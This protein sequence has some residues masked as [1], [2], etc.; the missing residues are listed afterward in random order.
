MTV[1]LSHY[2]V[3]I[4]LRVDFNMSN[5][6]DA[7]EK[8][9]NVRK[10]LCKKLPSTY[11]SHFF[12]KSITELSYQK[13]AAD[14]V[15]NVQ[16]KERVSQIVEKIDIPDGFPISK[17]HHNI[18][19]LLQFLNQSGISY[20]V[21]SDNEIIIFFKNNSNYILVW[22]KKTHEIHDEKY[23]IRDGV[24][25]RH[26]LTRSTA[27]FEIKELITLLKAAINYGIFNECVKMQPFITTYI[28]EVARRIIPDGTPY[29]L[30]QIWKSN[31]QELTFSVRLPNNGVINFSK[32]LKSLYTLG[33][34]S[35]QKHLLK[36]LVEADTMYPCVSVVTNWR[37]HIDF[38]IERSSVFF[39]SD[40]L[41]SLAYEYTCMIDN[42]SR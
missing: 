13:N 25:T 15:V 36:A 14:W 32:N 31:E 22:N 6:K 11:T 16:P 1:D 19:K 37:R 38:P 5:Y 26:K 42:F 27:G 10:I 8:F 17:N 24:V 35:T 39:S 18:A 4:S 28:Q 41:R 9:H 40:R 7:L 2:M 33:R 23:K 3:N 30:S 12:G 21:T 29:Q 20:R 34:Q